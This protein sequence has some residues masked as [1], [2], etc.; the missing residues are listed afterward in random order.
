MSKMQKSGINMRNTKKIE[1]LA[2]KFRK[3]FRS[4]PKAIQDVAYLYRDDLEISN[5]ANIIFRKNKDFSIKLIENNRNEE[6]QIE[7]LKSFFENADSGYQEAID[8]IGS[9]Q[10]QIIELSKQK[11]IDFASLHCTNLEIEF[12]RDYKESNIRSLSVSDILNENNYSIMSMLAMHWIEGI[13]IK[14]INADPFIENSYE[15]A[16]AFDSILI[17]TEG[18]RQLKAFSKLLPHEPTIDEIKEEYELKLSTMKDELQK[19]VNDRNQLKQKN[20]E[21]IS[22]Q[23]ELELRINQLVRENNELHEENVS[24]S[25]RKHEC[26]KIL[27]KIHAKLSQA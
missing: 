3:I 10:N 6:N 4:F 12:S 27:K 9:I 17:F 8:F 13:A 1:P 19:V 11:I 26:Y 25:K 14:E 18:Q 7:L 20:Q 23:N 24:L 21:M 15:L 2:T 22:K 16:V 5:K